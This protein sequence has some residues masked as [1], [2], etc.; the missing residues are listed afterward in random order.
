MM[1]PTALLINCARGPVI[2]IEATAKAL[3]D[4]MLAG[5]A[6]DVFEIEPPLPTDHVLVETKNTLL[7]PHVA[8]AT[9]ES[10]V[11]RAKI[12]F[13]N[14]YAWLDDGQINKIM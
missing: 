8:F 6:I 14:I 11:R 1:K 9:A 2:D 12:A 4:S 3:N 7:T 5:A 10:M 13:D